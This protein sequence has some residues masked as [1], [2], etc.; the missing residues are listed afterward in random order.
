MAKRHTPDLA[1]V[2]G[3]ADNVVGFEI[4][5]NVVAFS[6]GLG[7]DLGAPLEE[8]A[9]LAAQHMN[10]SQR[11]MLAAG[12]LLGSIKRECQ[13]GEFLALVEARGFEERAAQ[14]AMQY[15]QFVLS[16]PDGER[17]G[18]LEMHVSKVLALASADPEVI[19]DMLVSPDEGLSGLSVR[20]LRQRIRD[21]EAQSTNAAIER[22]TAV[23]ERDGL[24]KQLRRRQRDAEDGDGVP[25]LVADA[26]AEGAALVKKAELALAALHPLGVEVCNMTGHD[27]AGAWVKPSLRLL[28]S[29]LIA[30]RVQADGLIEQYAKAL[31]DDVKKLQS[32]PD[33][34]AFLDEAEIKAVAEEWS[35]LVATHQHEAAL[36][37]HERE[38]AKPKGKGRPKQAPQAPSAAG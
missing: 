3:A 31:G 22:D 16:R 23:A 28:M 18:L 5:D 13:P 7:V 4:S 14:R 2:K 21:L 25:M 29:G 9:D 35:R 6:V 8:R 12:L 17:N 20:E 30:L 15:A 34:L 33:A 10:R 37:S 19:E 38:Q 27:E 26:R 32:Q 11:H 36:R 24:A 1:P